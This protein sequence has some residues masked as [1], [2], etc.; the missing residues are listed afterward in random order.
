MKYITIAMLC[1]HTG[2]H[3]STILRALQRA[4]LT[5]AHFPGC[6]GCRLPEATART[7]LQRQWPDLP[8]LPRTAKA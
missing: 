7:F 6:K 1:A 5:A 3:R 8:P 4:G 2:R